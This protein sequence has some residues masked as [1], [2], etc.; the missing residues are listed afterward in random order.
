MSKFAKITDTKEKKMLEEVEAQLQTIPTIE[1]EEHALTA[2]NVLLT[3]RAVID[4]TEEKKSEY[5]KPM[6]ALIDKLNDEFAEVLSPF[7][8]IETKLKTGLTEFVEKQNQLSEIRL[9]ELREKTGDKDLQ[10]D[11]HLDKL[12]VGMGEVRFRTKTEVMIVDPALVPKKYLMS[13]V[14]VKAVEK[15]LEENPSLT[16]PG[17]SIKKTK[18]PALYVKKQ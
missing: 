14:D 17:V 13:V 10:L 9:Q 11:L 6:K 7:K 3:V 4:Q 15:A 2:A 8:L 12:S 18:S 1:T 16:I 5:A